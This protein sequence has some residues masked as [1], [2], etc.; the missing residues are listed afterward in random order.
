MMAIKK[1]TPKKATTKKRAAKNPAPTRGDAEKVY[2]A[3]VKASKNRHA[4]NAEEIS[5]H[6]KIPFARVQ[7]ALLELEKMA[8][9]HVAGSDPVGECWAAGRPYGHLPTANPTPKK[10]AEKKARDWYQ[11]EGLETNAKPIRGYKLPSAYVK[12]GRIVAIEYESDKYDGKRRVWRH[13]ATRKRDL[14]I[15][16]DGTTMVILPGFKITKRGIEG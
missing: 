7:K 10:K 2:T 16:T 12:V 9:V 6:S 14:H 3:I 4:L 15:S 5:I 1:K 13:E 11:N 8:L